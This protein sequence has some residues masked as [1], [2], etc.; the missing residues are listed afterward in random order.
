MLEISYYR[1]DDMEGDEEDWEREVELRLEMQMHLALLVCLLA[2]L[3]P[4]I[5][6]NN[7]DFAYTAFDS[8]AMH[9]LLANGYLMKPGYIIGCDESGCPWPPFKMCNASDARR[10]RTRAARVVA[11][12]PHPP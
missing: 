4:M 1:A 10:L 2:S 6:D 8:K 9:P 7:E 3:T 11:A 12:V 5:F